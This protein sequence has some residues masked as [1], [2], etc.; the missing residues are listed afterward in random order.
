MN[1]LNFVLSMENIRRRKHRHSTQIH[2]VRSRPR[3]QC[4]VSAEN[5]LNSSILEAH[6]ELAA[7]LTDSVLRQKASHVLKQIDLESQGCSPEISKRTSVKNSRNLIAE[8]IRMR[9][10]NM[11]KREDSKS[12]LTNRNHGMSASSR[13][14]EHMQGLKFI[15]SS[16]PI[17]PKGFLTLGGYFDLVLTKVSH[18]G[19]RETTKL[20]AEELTQRY[21]LHPNEVLRDVLELRK[22]R[23]SLFRSLDSKNNPIELK[24]S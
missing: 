10:K 11:H 1:I 14:R 15:E 9:A 17:I 22:I 19:T 12:S 2:I 24:P 5:S 21:I 8:Q 3:L 6:Q 18:S 20:L 7:T 16:R 4:F 13:S 23:Q